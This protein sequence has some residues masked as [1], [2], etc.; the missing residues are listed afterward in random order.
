MQICY[1]SAYNAG[2]N[3]NRRYRQ[4]FSR[5]EGEHRRDSQIQLDKSRRTK[6]PERAHSWN[7]TRNDRPN[8]G[9]QSGASDSTGLRDPSARNRF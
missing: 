8:A 2:P 6:N 9:P 1:C 5:D 4:P 7:G 3:F